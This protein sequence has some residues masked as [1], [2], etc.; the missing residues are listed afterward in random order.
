LPAAEA[1]R[2]GNALNH[3]IRI[4]ST[5]VHAGTFPAQAQY[6]SVA[7]AQAVL[8]AV[9][10]VDGEDAL[11]FRLIETGGTD[12]QAQV[13]L[14]TSLLGAIVSACEVDLMERPLPASTAAV[15]GETVTV[16]L[17]AHG[18]ASVKVKLAK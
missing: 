7:P 15:N 18:I 2:A 12:T 3:P 9:K 17:P 13:T 11:L 10:K 16:R 1:I 6:L 5:D 8:S 4:V 14:N